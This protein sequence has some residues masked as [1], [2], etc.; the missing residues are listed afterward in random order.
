MIDSTA[1]DMLIRILGPKIRQ[2]SQA[3]IL[4][5]EGSRDEGLHSKAKGFPESFRFEFDAAPWW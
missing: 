4:I 5:C 3:R 1:G 2:L